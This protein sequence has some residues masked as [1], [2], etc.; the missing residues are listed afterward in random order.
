LAQRQ[1]PKARRAQFHGPL[2]YPRN[3]IVDGELVAGAG[4]LQREMSGVYF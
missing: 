1:V 4:S 3:G 2:E